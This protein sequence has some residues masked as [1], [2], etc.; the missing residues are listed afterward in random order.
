MDGMVD[1]QSTRM[2]SLGVVIPSHQGR[3]DL[4]A[5]LLETLAVDRTSFAGYGVSV[6]VVV[7]DDSPAGEAERIAAL[8]QQLSMR[9]LSRQGN[10][11]RKR[12]DGAALVQGDIILF[13]DSDC[14]VRPGLLAMHLLA[15]TN[16]HAAAC[17]GLITF[18]GPTNWLVR[19]IQETP[20]LVPF[21]SPLSS[22]TVSWGPS[23]N[24]SVRRTIFEAVGG[25][26]E[27][28]SPPL[29][30][31]EDVDLGLRITATGGV[32]VTAPRAEVW[33]S[34]ETWS[35]VRGNIRRFIAWGRGDYFLIKKHPQLAF[36]DM[37]AFLIT[38]ALVWITALLV[39][40]VKLSLLPLLGI[41]LFPLVSLLLFGWLHPAQQV[42][43]TR[44]LSRSGSLL[45]LT[46]LDMGRFLEAWKT[47]EP[48]VAL[49]RFRFTQD[50]LFEEWPDLVLTGWVLLLAICLVG[51]LFW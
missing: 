15:Y 25:F 38:T 7:V 24:F 49:Q 41:F 8:C 43:M 40:L 9:F 22:P 36:Q 29:T 11:S 39:A 33:H 12:N 13:L 23:A 10:V 35:S 6:D 14:E 45:I 34:A 32:I 48:Q 3:V 30:G 1:I 19:V 20:L 28:L 21:A 44:R 50:Q 5:K 31:G 37:P 42:T 4:L 2:N 46:L 18:T 47:R 27:A 26:D 51:V 17:L 16:Q